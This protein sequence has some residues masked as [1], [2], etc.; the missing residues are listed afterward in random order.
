MSAPTQHIAR[1]GPRAASTLNVEVTVSMVAICEGRQQHTRS[2]VSEAAHV[3]VQSIAG[4]EGPWSCHGLGLVV[5]YLLCH[6]Q[7]LGVISDDIGVWA[8]TVSA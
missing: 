2:V 1:K 3:T 4:T 5:T 6:V 8:P 7:L